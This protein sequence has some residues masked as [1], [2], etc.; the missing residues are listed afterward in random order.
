MRN[1][2]RARRR[3]SIFLALIT[4]MGVAAC[5][6]AAPAPEP[7]PEVQADL[8]ADAPVRLAEAFLTPMDTLD[9]VDSPAAWRGPEG[10]LLLLATAK[11]SHVVMAYDGE[12]GALVGRMGSRGAAPGQFE[13]PN[14]IF[15]H[16]DHVYIVERDNRRVQVLTLPDFQPVATFGDD[17]LLKPYGISGFESEDGVLHLWITDDFDV[18]GEGPATWEN[19]VK[20]FAVTVTGSGAEATVAATLEGTVGDAEGPGRLVVV[21]SILAD[22]A[23]DRLLIADEDESQRS[24]KVFRLDGSFT[25]QQLGE[26]VFR[27]EPEGIALWGCDAGGYLLMADQSYDLNQFHVFDRESLEH[28]GTFAGEAVANTDGVAV[29]AGPAGSLGEGA[30]YA[31]HAD[32]GAVGFRWSDVA[33]ALGLEAT[34]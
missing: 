11:G 20:R 27:A 2:P 33:A 30:F 16:D 9:D 17:V 12:T 23:H 7:D 1:D 8:P 21:E 34:C 18:T 32:Q 13:R 10:Q 19:R 5:D 31:I 26:G 22:P 4:L 14:G 15:V 3:A 24:I 6:A 28:L 29:L 25:G